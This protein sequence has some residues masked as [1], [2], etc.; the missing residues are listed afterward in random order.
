[1]NNFKKT[2]KSDW[3]KQVKNISNHKIQSK[4]RTEFDEPSIFEYLFQFIND[5]N[6]FAIDIGAWPDGNDIDYIADKMK[7]NTLLLDGAK[8]KNKN[9]KR[10]WLTQENISEIL[11][12]Y[13]VPKSMEVLKIDIDNMDYRILEQ[14]LIKKYEPKIILFE[15]NPLFNFDEEYVKA[16]YPKAQKT[17]NYLDGHAQ[18]TSWYGASLG[19]FI[20]LGKKYNYELFYVSKTSEY[21]D[22]KYLHNSNNGWLI[23]K[24]FVRE[25]DELI[26]P[27]QLHKPFIETFKQPNNKRVCGSKNIDE[28]KKY[29]INENR[30]IKV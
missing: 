6:K 15:F 26:P 19:A 10:E 17:G 13:N 27:Q 16:Y 22:N 20:K 14:I 4:C 3:L 12:K 2:P 18:R 7:W 30:F 5:E 29:L 21:N 1:M 11:K 25:Q 8:C 24:R 9:I 28:L 23:H